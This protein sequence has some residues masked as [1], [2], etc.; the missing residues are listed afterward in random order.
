VRPPPAPA[1]PSPGSLA[2]L[3][4]TAGFRDLNFSDPPTKDMRLIE[5]DGDT[6]Y[7][8]RPG[9]ELVIGK[10]NVREITYGFYK[11]RLDSVLFETKGLI[12]SRA[13]LEVLREPSGLDRARLDQKHGDLCAAHQSEARCRGPHG[14]YEPLCGGETV[15]CD[16]SHVLR[17]TFSGTATPRCGRHSMH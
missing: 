4:F 12:K 3:D 5:G 11:E 8:K 16:V 17:H 7:Y 13:M 14:V 6:K 10:V 9:D 15:A 1:K 2:Y